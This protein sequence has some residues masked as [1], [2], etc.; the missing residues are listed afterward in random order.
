MAIAF[1][2]KETIKEIVQTIQEIETTQH[3]KGGEIRAAI[4]PIINSLLDRSII[5]IGCD[6]AFIME[7]HNGKSNSNGLGFYYADMTYERCKNPN[8]EEAVYWQYKSMP[9]SIFPIFD[10]LD[11]ERSFYGSADSLATIDPKLSQMIKANNTNFIVIVEI[12][13]KASTNKF[14]GMLGFSF[15]TDPQL[16]KAEINRYIREVRNRVQILLSLTSLEDV[17]LSQFNTKI[18]RN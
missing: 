11:R 1:S 17:D 16:S 12:P 2:P 3:A 10:Y 9:T 7:G 15:E 14:I 8:L 4:N 18:C 6:R 5:D 13:G